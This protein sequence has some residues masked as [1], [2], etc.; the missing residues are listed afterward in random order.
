MKELSS[1]GSSHV[2]ASSHIPELSEIINQLGISSYFDTVYNSGMISYEK[3][4]PDFFVATF[5]DLPREQIAFMVGDSIERD[6][7]G[8]IEVGINGIWF[9]RLYDDQKTNEKVSAIRELSELPKI[10]GEKINTK[11]ITG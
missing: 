9:N 4:N 1:Y 2:I 7:K 3:P 8:A 11:R 6:I 10:V 5:N